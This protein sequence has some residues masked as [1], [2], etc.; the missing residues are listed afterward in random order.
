M[1]SWIEF[2]ICSLFSSHIDVIVVCVFLY[3]YQE[4]TDPSVKNSHTTFILLSQI[5][6][7][8]FQFD[9]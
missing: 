3:I 5:L 6:V 8:N 7:F 9:C 2:L 4:R 1:L